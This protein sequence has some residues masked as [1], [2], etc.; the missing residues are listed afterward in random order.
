ME[1]AAVPLSS[2][3]VLIEDSSVPLKVETSERIPIAS[4]G[5]PG[6]EG[7]VSSF[8]TRSSGFELQKPFS[9]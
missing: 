5:V 9:L 2:E 3:E 7:L 6:D 8:Y 4:F 1:A